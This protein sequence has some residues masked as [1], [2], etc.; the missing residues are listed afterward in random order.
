MDF[1]GHR[2]DSMAK[3]KIAAAPLFGEHKERLFK[4][5][6]NHFQLF[7]LDVD[8]GYENILP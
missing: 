6:E 1:S 2:L 7:F 5:V 8:G 4:G 3:G